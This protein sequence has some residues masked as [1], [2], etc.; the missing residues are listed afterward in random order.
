MNQNTLNTHMMHPPPWTLKGE[1]YIFNYWVSPQFLKHHKSFGLTGS[2]LG[3]MIQVLLIR[4]QHTPVDAYDE[5][6]IL[7]HPLISKKVIS[8][9]PYIYVSSAISVEHGQALWGIPKQ[10]AAFEW[11]NDA[12]QT[13]CQMHASAQMLS[14]H[15][16]KFKNSRRFSV[17][18]HYFPRALLHCQQRTSA[19]QF[20]F[21][22]KFKGQL[23]RIKHANWQ[24]TEGLFP[25]FNQARFLQ[26][27]HVTD[28]E[29]YMPKAQIKNKTP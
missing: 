18:S 9:I 17:D 8:T 29:L 13:V 5:L 6:L 21:H 10:L 2:A 11:Y 28:F 7:D 22:L 14:I 20:N 24:N 16:E 26:G 25:D 23:C 15:I 1:A 3:R 19:Q 27:F 4:Y 12:K